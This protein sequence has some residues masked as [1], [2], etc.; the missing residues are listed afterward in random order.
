MVQIGGKVIRFRLSD[1]LILTF[2][3]SRDCRIFSKYF[4]IFLSNLVDRDTGSNST[5]L[6]S[7]YTVSSEKRTPLD[8]VQ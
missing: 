3:T 2:H 1:E 8:I 7:I 6:R 5:A 4:L